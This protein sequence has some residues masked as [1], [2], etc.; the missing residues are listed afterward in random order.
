[1]RSKFSMRGRAA[2]HDRRFFALLAALCAALWVAC[3][4]PVRSTLPVAFTPCP[5]SGV[6]P[7]DSSWRQVRASG[8]TFCIPGSWQP[9]RPAS[10]SLDAR[11]WRG[12]EGS[13]A[14]NLGRSESIGPPSRR[15]DIVGTVATVGGMPPPPPSPVP[16]MGRPESCS[17]PMSTPYTVDSVVVVVTQT[18]CR[19]TWTTTAWSTAPP[20]YVQGEAH[21]AE[22]AKLLNAI[23]VTIRF[24]SLRP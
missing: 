11:S 3:T 16:P 22:D 15:V 9:S 4:P 14:W 20:I 8:F 21:S 24:A 2:P 7:V 12:K 19:G 5:I 6:G 1:V 13:V 10:D 17:Q 18:A 23:M